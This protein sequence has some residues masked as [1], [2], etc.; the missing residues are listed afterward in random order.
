MPVLILFSHKLLCL[1]NCLQCLQLYNVIVDT[2]VTGKKLL[3]K[4][5]LQT[6]VTIIPLSKISGRSI[7]AHT[8]KQAEALVGN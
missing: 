6:R 3:Q 1:F 4:G 7:D 2:E 5:Q 8:V